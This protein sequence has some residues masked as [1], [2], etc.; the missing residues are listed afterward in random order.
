MQ[1]FT[2]FVETLLTKNDG[3][4]LQRVKKS[5]IEATKESDVEILTDMI[6]AFRRI[7]EEKNVEKKNVLF[8][9]EGEAVARKKSRPNAESPSIALF[10]RF[11]EEL[12]SKKHPLV[13][14]V[15][16]WQWLDPSSLALLHAVSSSRKVSG[17][18]LLGTCRGNE[19]GVGD[20]LSYVLR[21]LEENSKV[22]ITDIQ[23][24]DLGHTAVNEIIADLLGS[25]PMEVAS[26]ALKVH[27]LTHGNGFFVQQ[28]L[29]T[30]HDQ[31]LLYFRNKKWRWEESSIDKS[32]LS[33]GSARIPGFTIERASLTSPAV[34]R[35]LQ[36]AAC[37]GSRFSRQHVQLA[38]DSQGADIDEA[39]LI[40]VQKGVLTKRQSRYT[41]KW[42]HDRFQHAAYTLIPEGKRAEYHVSIG[43]R[44]LHKFSE[45]DLLQNTLLVTNQ[46]LFD[47]SFLR[48]DKERRDAAALFCAAGYRAAQSSAFEES[49]RYFRAGI[50]MLPP[51]TQWEELYSLTLRLYDGAA[52]MEFCLGNTKRVDDLAATVIEHARSM[53]DKIRAYETR[54]LSLSA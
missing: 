14:L 40:L 17:F 13:L 1:A 42:S 38:V 11:V 27:E 35:V 52:E 3:G 24:G 41:Y 8:S 2:A 15:D 44:L 6:P 48:D 47:V 34:K 39:F 53:K 21:S 19:V 29:M 23:V 36:V 10:C 43:R 20:D 16:D 28:C 54:I 32:N 51:A 37:L 50:D 12:C 18:M 45:A 7:L 26:L 49:A 5:I 9:M 46:L 31:G 25:E 4:E 33:Q 22:F 30:L